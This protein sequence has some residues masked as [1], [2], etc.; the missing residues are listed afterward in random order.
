MGGAWGIVPFTRVPMQQPHILQTKGKQ[1]VKKLLNWEAL[2]YSM[3]VTPQIR[4]Q[5]GKGRRM[6]TGVICDRPMT[7]PEVIRLFAA[8]KK[9]KQGKLQEKLDKAA[10]AVE[11]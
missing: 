8:L 2:D 3:P 11:H 9:A 4:E 5:L 7:C 1:H 10:A 6:T